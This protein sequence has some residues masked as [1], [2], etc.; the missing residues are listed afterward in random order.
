[1]YQLLQK[2]EG[3]QPAAHCP[4]QKHPKSQKKACHI[5]AEIEFRRAIYRLQ[6]S[7]RTSKS[8]RRAGIAV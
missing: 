7:N 6:R 4:A 2:A 1:M 3:T 5:E 8:G